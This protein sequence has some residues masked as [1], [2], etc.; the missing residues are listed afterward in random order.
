MLSLSLTDNIRVM[1]S[2]KSL[3]LLL[4]WFL[5]SSLLMSANMAPVANI[6]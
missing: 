5:R 2:K 6:F 4:L 1:V 3:F